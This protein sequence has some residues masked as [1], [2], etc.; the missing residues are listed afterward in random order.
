MN[1]NMESVLPLLTPEPWSFG[2][3][4]E[5]FRQAPMYHLIFEGVLIIFIV[6]L[7][8]SKSYSIQSKI[9][10]TKKEKDQLIEEWTPEPLVPKL[11]ADY[12]PVKYKLV[13]Q[14]GGS[15]LT[16]DGKQGINLGTFNFLGMLGRK[17]TEDAAVKSLKK[18]GVGTC[19]PRGF[20]GTMDVHMNFEQR[21]A[22]FFGMEEGILYSYGFST[23]ASCIPAYSKRGDIIFCDEGVCFAVQMGLLA[24]R[25]QI[26]F[27]KHNDMEDLE[28]LLEEQAVEDKKNPKK[29]KKTRK[30]MVVEGLYT[31][32][33]QITPIDKLVEFKYKYK[34][35]IFLDESMSFGVLGK[36][37][38]GVTQHC[39]IDVTDV[40]LISASMETALGTLGGFCVGSK[41][42]VDHQRLSGLG[43]CFSASLPPMLASAAMAA[44]DLMDEDPTMAVRLQKRSQFVHEELSKIAELKLV[45]EPVSPI[46]HLQVRE[47]GDKTRPEITKLLE[48]IVD[49]ALDEGVVLTTACYLEE[50]E[51]FLIPPSIRIAVGIAPTD[52]QIVMAM[53]VIQKV[54]S[55]I[56]QNVA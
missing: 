39:G 22:S 29:A 18:Y 4:F 55:E 19:G 43:Y 27:F 35:R 26:K 21:I 5:A 20:Y 33:G 52:D 42:V 13:T 23:V 28:R 32:T 44:L 45:G 14:Q 12:E 17:E 38:L 53:Q 16:V 37:G 3:L 9:E 2:E 6:R 41:F 49:K 7:L 34:V 46:K 30:F 15:M 48:S 11:P 56:L 47:C 10:L 40:D 24:S 36:T 31:N 51:A 54:A 8:F 25:S 50:E 1:D